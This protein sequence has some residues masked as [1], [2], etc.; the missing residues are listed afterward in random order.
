[1]DWIHAK[2]AHIS[3]RVCRKRWREG[4]IERGR[5]RERESGR[6][7]DREGKTVKDKQQL[8]AAT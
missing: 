2:D 3:Y 5:E 6:E 4:E 7:R 1:M 8:A